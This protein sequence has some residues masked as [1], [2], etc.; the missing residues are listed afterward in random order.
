MPKYDVEIVFKVTAD[1]E[2]DAMGKVKAAIDP[3]D[4]EAEIS[5]DEEYKEEEDKKKED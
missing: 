1:S 3:L 4:D 5:L 2:E